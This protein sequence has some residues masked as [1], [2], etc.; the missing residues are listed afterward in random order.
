MFVRLLPAALQTLPKLS[1]AAPGSCASDHRYGPVDTNE[2]CGMVLR[3]GWKILSGFLHLFGG[4]LTG[5]QMQIVILVLFVYFLGV[6]QGGHN[7]CGIGDSPSVVL[8]PSN[9]SLIKVAFKK[10]KCFQKIIFWG[11]MA[12][13]SSCWRFVPAFHSSCNRPGWALLRWTWVSSLWDLC[14]S[15]TCFS[16]VLAVIWHWGHCSGS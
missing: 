15:S 2:L 5:E 8:Q 4:R 7:S 14:A 16:R 12:L 3:L 1:Y 9:M 11:K 6:A 10:I 13:R